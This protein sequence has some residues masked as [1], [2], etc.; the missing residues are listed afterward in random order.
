MK[1]C[2]NILNPL[3]TQDKII[4]HYLINYSPTSVIRWHL[5]VNACHLYPR[6]EL[7]MILGS[8]TI[9]ILDLIV[10]STLFCFFC[11]FCFSMDKIKASQLGN[12]ELLFPT[13]PPLVFLHFLG[14]AC[15]FHL[16]DNSLMLFPTREV[17][18]RFIK[19]FI[20]LWGFAIFG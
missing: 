13:H 16:L 2:W 7:F 3:T 12:W 10:D 1:F 19:C 15:Y 5:K 8:S 14:L 6:N 20:H 17:L 4:N 18:D 9:S 11:F